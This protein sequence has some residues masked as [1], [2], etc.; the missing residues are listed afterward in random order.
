[1]GLRPLILTKTTVTSS[2][3]HYYPHSDNF[4]KKKK[5]IPLTPTDCSVN[6][7]QEIVP[8]TACNVL[9]AED[10][11]PAV[12]WLSLIRQALNPPKRAHTFPKTYSNPAQKPRVSFSDLLSMS[13]LTDDGD[14][15]TNP[16][17]IADDEFADSFPNNLRYCLAAS[18]QMVGIFLCV[19]VRSEL[20]RHV[21]S[22][23]VSCVGRGIMGYMGNKVRSLNDPIFLVISLCLSID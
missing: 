14:P 21:T 22:L 8:L 11:G 20:M 18:K 1:M 23:K 13:D 2:K 16:N 12:K 5:F 3:W 15:S 17:S 4:C 9:G 7:F 10:R 19:W 6:R